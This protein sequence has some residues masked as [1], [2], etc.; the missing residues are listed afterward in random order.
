MRGL[1]WMVSAC[2]VVLFGLSAWKAVRWAGKSEEYH[3]VWAEFTIY[4]EDDVELRNWLRA[5]PGVV[6][7]SVMICRIG[8]EPSTRLLVAFTFVRDKFDETPTPD[9]DR[10]CQLLG[11]E[12]PALR[13]EPTGYTGG[14]F[15]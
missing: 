5:Q 14:C 10:Q 3:R 9:L 1:K 4:P 8:P 12:R 13:F 15:P 2:V 7:H 11:Y 6:P